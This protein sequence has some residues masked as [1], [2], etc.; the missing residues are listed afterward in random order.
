MRRAAGA[1]G[2]ALART[3]PVM[4]GVVIAVFF[5]LRLVP[6]DPAAMILGERATPESVAALRA[7]LGLDAPLWRQFAGFLGQVVLHFDTG[8]SLVSGV[9][10]RE[11]V[12]A[13]APVSAGIVVLALLLAVLIAVPLALVA[14]LRRDGW[15]D[16]LVRIVPAVGMGM[17]LFW[18]GLLLIIVFAVQLGWF[19][20]GGVGSGPGEPLRSL[21]LPALAVALGM[22]PPLIRSLRAQ[23][24]DALEA[25]FVTTLR[26]ARVPERRIV[27]RHVMRSAA[28][29]TLTLLGVN[30]AY[31]IGGTLVVERVFGINGVGSLLFQSIGTRDFPVVQGVALY[32]AIAVVLVTA[33]TEALASVLDPRVRRRGRTR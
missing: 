15:A 17:P 28:L 33:A 11:L 1:V 25:D 24:V 6:G 23:L 26:A 8:A 16:H 3:A 32:C 21:F 4:L 2:R 19:P 29:P 12:I 5:L 20:V 22:A 9:S 13:T 31:L 18:L 7:E 10:T 27:W 14:A 30:T